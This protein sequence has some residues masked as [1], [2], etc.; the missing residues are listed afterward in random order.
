MSQVFANNASTTLSGAITNTATSL[1]VSSAANFPV[2]TSPDTFYMTLADPAEDTWEIV[3]VT[4]TV[5]TTFTVAR[6][7]DGTTAL[8]WATGSTVEMRPVAQS[9]RD[10]VAHPAGQLVYGDSEGK[11]LISS[12]L[13]TIAAGVI[14]LVGVVAGASGVTSSGPV[15]VTNATASTSTTTGALIISGG[16]GIAG[17]LNVGSGILA[18]TGTFS[19]SISAT[20]GTFSGTGGYPISAACAG[21]APWSVFQNSVGSGMTNLSTWNAAG[22]TLLFMPNSAS[23]GGLQI[24][25]SGVQVASISNVGGISATTGTFSGSISATTGTFSASTASTTTTT[26]AVTVAGGVGIVGALYVGGQTNFSAAIDSTGRGS[27]A[28]LISAGGLGVYGS[29]SIGNPVSGSVSAIV[30]TKVAI[31]VG[32]TTLYF[33]ASTSAA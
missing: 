1:V 15:A 11:G 22:A 7:Q 23:G 33:L 18:T 12:A 2:L 20:T 14:T 28:V 3:K 29:I 13:G 4:A 17:A 32:S 27:G 8:A 24:Y 6:G 19:G 25:T 5:G 30:T 16:A 26:G 21:Q 31:V 9:L 10:M